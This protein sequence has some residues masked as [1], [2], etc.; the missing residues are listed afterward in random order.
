MAKNPLFSTCRQGE[1]R[2]RLLQR[3]SNGDIR[4]LR[5]PWNRHH[6]ADC[7]H[8][9]PLPRRRSKV[10]STRSTPGHRAHDASAAAHL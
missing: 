4:P 6:L 7:D 9:I 5:S 8:L 2:H 1:N 3:L 10:A